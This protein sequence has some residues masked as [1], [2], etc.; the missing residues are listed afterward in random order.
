MPRPRRRLF[1]WQF[2][3]WTFAVYVAILRTLAASPAVTERRFEVPSLAPGPCQ[4]VEVTSGD[5]FVVRP[6]GS[7]ED[8][9]ARLLST[10]AATAEQDGADRAV[11]AQKFARDFLAGRAVQLRLDNHRLDSRGR[12][13]AYLEADGELLNLALIEAGLA[14]FYFFPGNS[15]STDR[16]LSNAQEAARIAR[17][18]LWQTK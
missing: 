5:T 9:V 7:D 18:G 13:L 8:V 14:R 10:Q 3:A 6:K 11:E 15:A 2:W 4:V 17:R 16:R 1:P 12:Y